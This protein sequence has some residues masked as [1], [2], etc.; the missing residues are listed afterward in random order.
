MAS[1]YVTLKRSGGKHPPNLTS[2]GMEPANKCLK[3][4]V[5][6]GKSSAQQVLLQT[7]FSA[8]VVR[9]LRAPPRD[10]L[11]IQRLNKFEVM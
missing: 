5:P 6:N 11:I 9:V 1:N 2:Q 10:I 8:H 7:R 4:R 3:K